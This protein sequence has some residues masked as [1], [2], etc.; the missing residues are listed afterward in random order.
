MSMNRDRAAKMLGVLVTLAALSWFGIGTRAQAP[1]S[2]AV[3][4]NVAADPAPEQPIPYSHRVHLALGL[5]CG[6][7][8]TGGETTAQMGLPPTSTCMSCHTAIAADRPAIQRLA[9]FAAALEPIPWQRVY[10]VLPGVTWSH[11]PHVT[12]GV[13]CAACHGDVAELDAMRMTTSVTA[14][15]SCIG[16]HESRAVGT[17]CATCHAWPPP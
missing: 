10:E 1:A 6:M 3:P 15:A 4:R 2:P 16:C 7:C 13:A 5:T 12:A 17:A 14:M 8:H 11:A 9:T